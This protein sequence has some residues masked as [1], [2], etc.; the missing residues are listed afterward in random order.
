VSAAPPLRVELFCVDAADAS[1][2]TGL[3]R[4][5]LGREIIAPSIQS[6]DARSLHLE[7]LASV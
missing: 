1:V 4:I 7:S 3:A 2:E 6:L 5:T